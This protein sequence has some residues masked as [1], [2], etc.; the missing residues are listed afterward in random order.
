MSRFTSDWLN[1]EML[2]M[3]GFFFEGE[4]GGGGSGAGAGSGEGSGGS[5]SGEGAGEGEGGS[6]GSGKTYDEATVKA[7]RDEN[8]KARRRLKELEDAQKKADDAKLSETERL[9]KE[10]DEAKTRADQAEQKSRARVARAEVLTAATEASFHKPSLAFDL[11]KDKIEYDDDGEPKNVAALIERLA[12]DNP[13]LIKSEGGGQT[14]SNTNGASGRGG[15]WTKESAAKLAE[16]NP[17]E[18]FRRQQAGEF[19]GLL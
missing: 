6:G 17:L 9:K 13:F 16:T 10:A 11:I 15:K 14:T 12:T 2:P 5:G 19:K 3:P 8:A 1:Y 4:G 18:F 7:L